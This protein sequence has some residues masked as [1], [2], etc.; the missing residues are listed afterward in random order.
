MIEDKLVSL[1]YLLVRDC[2][3]AGE[4]VRVVKMVQEQGNDTPKF[5]NPH[6]EAFS[7]DMVQRMTGEAS[8]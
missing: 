8:R 5:T 4:I 2:A 6:L 1:M 3:P 7:R